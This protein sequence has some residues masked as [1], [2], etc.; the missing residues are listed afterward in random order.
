MRWLIDEMLPPSIADELAARGHDAVAV[1]A[2]GLT[3]AGDDEVY[4]RAVDEQRV[5]V[6]ENFGDYAALTDQHTAAGAA[7]ATVVFVRK[8]SFPADGLAHHLAAHLHAWA[9][10]N[11]E[12]FPSIHWP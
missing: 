5:I 9:G 1:T 11:P 6:T 10:S 8:S 7:T 2:V 4:A 12:P 3:G